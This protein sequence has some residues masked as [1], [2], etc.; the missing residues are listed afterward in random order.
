MKYM[1][2][3]L[4]PHAEERNLLARKIRVIHHRQET[5]PIA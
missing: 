5:P 1:E 3:A 4:I 2:S